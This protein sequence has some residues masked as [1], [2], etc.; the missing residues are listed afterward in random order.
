M[1]SISRALLAIA[2]ITLLSAAAFGQ[3]TDSKGKSIRDFPDYVRAS[4]AFAEVIYRKAVLESELEGLLVKYTNQYPKVAEIRFQLAELELALGKLLDV[5]ADEKSKLS[6]ALGKL[7]VQRAEYAAELDALKRKYN[8]SHP[9][10]K[11][12]ARRLEIF[13]K[14]IL[15]I[16]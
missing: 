6:I 16:L 14:A 11:Q 8:D 13:D 9:E 3:E 5:P 4:P 15:R 12:A 2:I 10:V 1:K 7:M